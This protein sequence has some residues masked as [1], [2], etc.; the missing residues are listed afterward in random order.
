RYN[1]VTPGDQSS[2]A[3]NF[4]LTAN[5]PAAASWYSTIELTWKDEKGNSFSSRLATPRAE[6]RFELTSADEYNM[7]EAGNQTKKVKVLITATLSDGSRVIH[8]DNAEAIIA[9]AYR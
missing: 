3:A 2:C 4:R 9:V 6:D 7:N 8:I 5:K 1:A